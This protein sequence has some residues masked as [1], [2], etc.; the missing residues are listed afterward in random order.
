MNE[1]NSFKGVL[2]CQQPRHYIKYMLS[3]SVWI[4][5]NQLIPDGIVLYLNCNGGYT[6]THVIQC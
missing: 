6:N 3:K 2:F 1:L 4:Y 5:S